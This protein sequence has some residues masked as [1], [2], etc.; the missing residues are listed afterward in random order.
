MKE[1]FSV[2][3]I[4]LVYQSTA[5]AFSTDSENKWKSFVN[6]SFKS[7]ITNSAV[8]DMCCS[9]S[10][11]KELCSSTF[12]DTKLKFAQDTGWAAYANYDSIKKAIFIYPRASAVITSE[13]EAQQLVLH[14]LGHAC[15]FSIQKAANPQLEALRGYEGSEGSE[16]AIRRTLG[17]TYMTCL[18]TGTEK[19][20]ITDRARYL[21]SQEG[22]AEVFFR[23]FLKNPFAVP[24]T[25]HPTYQLAWK[26]YTQT[27][28]KH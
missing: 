21:V 25:E 26:C 14:E 16:L 3:S 20:P 27:F 17:E 13:S 15:D 23:P 24:R 9:H 11:N 10:E 7:A 8:V 22:F 5:F 12:L 2:L 4:L 19:L 1:L 18:E 6:S 28:T